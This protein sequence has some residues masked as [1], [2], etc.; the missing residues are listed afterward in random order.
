MK[1]CPVCQGEI[2]SIRKDY[3][4]RIC[5]ERARRARKRGQA[6]NSPADLGKSPHRR[7]ATLLRYGAVA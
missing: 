6:I 4:S 5:V 7:A 3:C 2:L 1:T